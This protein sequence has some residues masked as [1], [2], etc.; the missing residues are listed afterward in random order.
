MQAQCRAYA[1][2]ALRC[3]RQGH[4]AEES[5]TSTATVLEPHGAKQIVLALATSP[6]IRPPPRNPRSR[7]VK[8]PIPVGHCVD[9]SGVSC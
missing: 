6:V 3:R 9:D 5:K 7:P 4:A 8:V 2:E 1:L